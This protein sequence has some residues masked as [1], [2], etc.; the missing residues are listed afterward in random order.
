MLGVSYSEIAAISR[1]QHKSQ[2]FGSRGSR[3]DRLEFL[4][5]IKGEKAEKDIFDG[6]DMT[7]KRVKNADKVQALVDK[8]VIE[9]DGENPSASLPTLLEIR[10]AIGSLEPGVWQKR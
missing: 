5:H 8:A 1:S 10:K 4:E 7:W 2:G 3:G 6:I 9:F